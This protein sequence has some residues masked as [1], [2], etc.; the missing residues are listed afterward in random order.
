MR[1]LIPFLGIVS[2]GLFS[3]CGGPPTGTIQGFVGN[4][5]DPVSHARIELRPKQGKEPTFNGESI[6]GGRYIMDTQARQGIP[7]GTYEVF[8][9]YYT[10]P[11]GKPL[12]G[13]EEADSLISDG[14]AKPQ[15]VKFDLEVTAEEQNI[16]FDVSKGDPVPLEE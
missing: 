13:G 9:T 16:D 11:E 14:T 7:V 2:L 10:L 1:R 12:P 4:D 6:E 3:G 5:G 8:I 15:R